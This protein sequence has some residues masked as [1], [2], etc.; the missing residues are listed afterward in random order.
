M[1]S[2]FHFHLEDKMKLVKVGIDG[3]AITKLRPLVN[4]LDFVVIYRSR[5]VGKKG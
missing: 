5:V 1:V 2:T 4:I 3:P